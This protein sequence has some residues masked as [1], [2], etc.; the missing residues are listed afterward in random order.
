MDVLIS[1]AA[2]SAMFKSYAFS[3]GLRRV[4]RRTERQKLED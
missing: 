2:I 3:D 1:A 4:R